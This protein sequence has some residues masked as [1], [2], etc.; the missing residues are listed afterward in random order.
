MRPQLARAAWPAL[1]ILGLSLALASLA[2]E[3]EPIIDTS[4]LLELKARAVAAEIADLREY[5]KTLESPTGTKRDRLRELRKELHQFYSSTQTSEPPAPRAGYRAAE[6]SA[7]PQARETYRHPLLAQLTAEL[8]GFYLEE[9]KGGRLPEARLC[10]LMKRGYLVVAAGA[11]PQVEPLALENAATKMFFFA[12]WESVGSGDIHPCREMTFYTF[13]AERFL[14]PKGDSG[15]VLN[16]GPY[17][18][19]WLRDAKGTNFQ[20]AKGHAPL[21]FLATGQPLAENVEDLR[22][23]LGLWAE[24]TR[25]DGLKF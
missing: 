7:S 9:W 16:F 24:R 18:L 11:S 22:S 14:L 5:R 19:N 23:V 12:L 3:V 4:V 25:R 1:V 20:W 13:H 2:E 21:S 8:M 15:W 17:R 6:V 10:E